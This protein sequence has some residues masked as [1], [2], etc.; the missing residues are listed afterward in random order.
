MQEVLFESDIDFEGHTLV[1][2]TCGSSA[3]DQL[4]VDLLCY[5]YGK[6]VGR[7]LS[8]NIEM[9]ASPNPYAEKDGK[10][11]SS[12]DIY[13]GEIPN[14]GKVVLLRIAT[15]LPKQKRM[16]LDF[17]KDI[18]TFA[19]NHKLSGIVLIRSVSSVFCLESQIRD[20]PFAL[21]AFGPVLDQIKFKNLEPFGEG[22]EM[23][24]AS[25]LGEFFTCFERNAKLPLSMLLFFVHEGK[26]FNEAKFF[27]KNITGEEIQEPYS[28]KPLLDY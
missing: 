21:R 4:C 5:K 11:A 13:K 6:Q 9:T 8:D 7:I 12:V 3:V 26:G 2:P 22:Q 15:M 28:W 1:L 24:K 18:L 14:I 25:V 19:E 20:W 17:T 10:I 23:L 16:I 27:A